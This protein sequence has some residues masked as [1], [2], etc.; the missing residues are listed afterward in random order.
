MPDDATEFAAP[1]PLSVRCAGVA[2][3]MDS[4]WLRSSGMRGREVALSEAWTR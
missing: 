3:G 4:T 1:G 2:A